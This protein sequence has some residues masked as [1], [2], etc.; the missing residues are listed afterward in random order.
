VSH[1]LDLPESKVF[2]TTSNILEEE[3]FMTILL[4]AL[5]L[6]ADPTVAAQTA[7]PAN[8]PPPAARKQSERKICRIDTS[9]S[10]SRLRKRVC[11]TQTEWDRKAA[12]VSENDL[13][14]I[15]AK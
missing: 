9:D 11:L 8:A 1:T 6:A 10:T 3:C 12:G 7:V 4:G 2:S 15:G 14:T 5:L 13:K